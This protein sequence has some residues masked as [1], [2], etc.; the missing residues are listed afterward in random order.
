[1]APDLRELLAHGYALRT[2]QPLDLFPQTYHVEC[3]VSL[4][5]TG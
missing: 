2:V 3:V 5:R 1:L 4:E